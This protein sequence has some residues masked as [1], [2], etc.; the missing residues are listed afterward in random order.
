M[1]LQLPK[2]EQG[3]N[4]QVKKHFGG[5]V[6]TGVTGNIDSLG[7][8]GVTGAAGKIGNSSRGRGGKVGKPNI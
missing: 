3:E 2:E 7:F 8:R 6:L 4:V 1:I 5:G